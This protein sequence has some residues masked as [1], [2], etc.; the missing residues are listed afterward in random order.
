M[1][2]IA[3]VIVI[4][5][6]YHMV[7]LLAS[8]SIKRDKIGTPLGAGES[9]F[10]V[11]IP[12][13]NEQNVIRDSVK[14]IFAA[15]YPSDKFTI[16]VVAD[17]CTDKTVQCARNAGAK[18]IERHNPLQPGKQFA[19][20]WAFK[21]IDLDNFD[22]VVILDADNHIDPNFFSVLN[23]HLQAGHKVLQAYEETKNPNDSWVSMN[24]AYIY[25][26]M[27]RM[28][29][30]RTALGMSAWLAG[31]GVC[32]S[33]EVLKKI[34]WNVTTIVDDV[35]FTCKLLLNGEK[36]TLADGAVIYDQK[37]ARLMDSMKQRLRWIRGQTQVGIKYLP[38]LAAYVLKESFKGNYGQAFRAFDAIMWLPMQLI[39]LASFVYSFASGGFCYL[40][41]L[42]ITT[43]VFYILPLV[44]EKVRLRK[45]WK[46]LAT[47][48]AFFLTWIPITAYGVVTYG[49]QGWWRTP[50]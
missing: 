42:L 34:G 49:K 19:L 46:Y 50:H 3:F 11:F 45:A 12:A 26:Y 37:P 21:Q 30:I 48:G 32:I 44:A 29:M 8:L 38:K 39:I 15:H 7:F 10:A 36:V 18:V 20:E 35:E 14:S 33:T 22:A 25:W 13:H 31:T 28:Q 27:F 2:I 16:H 24:N 47:S 4:Y 40:L 6:L 17:N 43:P 23:H 5:Y 1:K 41:T 9:R